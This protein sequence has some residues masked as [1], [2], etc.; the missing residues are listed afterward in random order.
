MDGSSVP[1][2]TIDALKK[3]FA[4]ALG[5]PGPAEL[6][7]LEHSFLEQ[8]LEDYTGDETPELSP[9]DFAAVLADFWKYG[10]VRQGG[11]EPMVRLIRAQGA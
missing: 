6:D 4:K 9:E 1:A 7:R 11:S 8:A 3:V 5:R 10:E 2:L